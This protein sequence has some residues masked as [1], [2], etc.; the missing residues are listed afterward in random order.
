MKDCFFQYRKG[1]YDVLSTLTYQGQPI[2]VMEFAPKGNE[3]PYIQIMNMSSTFERDD[4]KFSQTLSVDIMV[5]TMHSGEPGEFG[6]KQTD[7]IM[8]NVMQLLITKGVTPADRAKHIV[9]TDFMDAGCYLLALNYQPDFDGAKTTIRK[10]L[11]I[12]TM[13]DEK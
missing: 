2:P 10:I 11:T 8:T 9:M 3:E 5:V 1:L 6:S 4:D 7:D 13:I 12:Q